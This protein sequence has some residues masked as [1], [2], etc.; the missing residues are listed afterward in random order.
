MQQNKY[1]RRYRPP[2]RAP[3]RGPPR[4]TLRR[5]CLDLS[6]TQPGKSLVACH[7][8]FRRW[9]ELS[10]RIIVDQAPSLSPPNGCPVREQVA[11]K[12]PVQGS[13]GR[14]RE[15]GGTS[16]PQNMP[17]RYLLYRRKGTD[18]RERRESCTRYSAQVPLACLASPG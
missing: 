6:K 1:C 11:G 9:E 7:W 5:R 3:P 2:P 15:E 4:A 10:I 8:L 17:N 12:S 13:R 18:E 14:Q 16:R